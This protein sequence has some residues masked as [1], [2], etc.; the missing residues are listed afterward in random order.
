MSTHTSPSP[1]ASRPTSLAPAGTEKISA[2]LRHL[3]ADVFALYVKTKNYHWHM[4]GPHFRDYHL[5]LD[6]Q[7]GQ[8]FAMID[9]LAERGR[10]LGGT[11]LRS[12]ADIAR[13]QRIQDSEET[14]LT[15]NEML[16]RLFEDNKEFA[17]SLREIHAI[18]DEHGDVATASLLENWIDETEQRA[19]F[20]FETLKT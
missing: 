1:T 5:L 18:C 13:H 20:L 12:V 17:N 19:W 2:A 10:K 14:S 8:L 3:L 15:A 16:Q 11:S 4:R 9:P 6:D 7:A